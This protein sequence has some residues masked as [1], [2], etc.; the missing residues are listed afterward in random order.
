MSFPFIKEAKVSNCPAFFVA[1]TF[2]HFLEKFRNALPQEPGG[3][4]GVLLA[5]FSF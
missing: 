2:F 3:F 5:G 1:S 4:C